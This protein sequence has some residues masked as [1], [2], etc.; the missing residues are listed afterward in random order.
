[1]GVREVI[2]LSDAYIEVEAR[3]GYLFVVESGQLTRLGELR[4]YTARLDAV[5]RRLGRDRALIDARGELGEPPQA[6]R[7]AMWAWL[8]SEDRPI[9]SFAFVLPSEMAVARVN[10]TALA[11]KAKLRA[12]DSVQAAQRWLLRDPR[13]SSA[14]TQTKVETQP[15]IREPADSGRR[16]QLRPGA[17]ISKD[18]PADHVNLPPD[19]DGAGGSQVA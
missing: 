15:P 4:R 19:E 9:R 11:C 3:P 2:E 12:F 5:A 6:V 1:M 14:G 17:Y 18:A 10:M 8:C 7:Q 13:L 16:P